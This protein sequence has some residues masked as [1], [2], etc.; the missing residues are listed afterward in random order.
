MQ[1]AMQA[2]RNSTTCCMTTSLVLFAVHLGPWRPHQRLHI[3][4]AWLYVAFL[5]ITSLLGLL[6]QLES[7]PSTSASQH[8]CRLPAQAGM[9]VE[10]ACSTCCNIG[11]QHYSSA[12]LTASSLLL[13]PLCTAEDTNYHFDVNW[14]NL[15][16][17]LDR[18]G[19]VAAAA[20]AA[21]CC[22]YVHVMSSTRTS[23]QLPAWLLLMLQVY[24]HCHLPRKSPGGCFPVTPY[25]RG[26]THVHPTQHRLLHG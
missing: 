16:P 2:Q 4:C 10:H 21:A 13:C 25:L 24:A 6:L 8:A 7:K 18:W 5:S 15:E 12:M 17:A 14:D 26:I 23:C 19:H 20:V 1:Q 11:K 3:R 9:C 22:L